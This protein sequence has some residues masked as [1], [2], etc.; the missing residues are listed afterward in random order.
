MPYKVAK[1]PGPERVWLK[2][3]DVKEGEPETNE[4]DK[5]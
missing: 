3:L 5:T 2:D 4:K 1:A